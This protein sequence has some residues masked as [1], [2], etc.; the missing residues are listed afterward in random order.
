MDVDY[1]IIIGQ[2]PPFNGETDYDILKSVKKGTFRYDD[3]EW[4][5]IS[6]EAKKFI[7][8]MLT[9][10]IYAHEYKIQNIGS[11]QEKL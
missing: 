6:S 11:Q 1:A 3:D 7:N 4:S 2:A 5:N 8:K 10:G 9:L